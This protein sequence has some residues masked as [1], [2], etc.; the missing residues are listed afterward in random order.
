MRPAN[1]HGGPGSRFERRDR[2][3]HC[4][5]EPLPCRNRASLHSFGSIGM[6]E[7]APNPT[8]TCNRVVERRIACTLPVIRGRDEF[9]RDEL[10]RARG[11]RRVKLQQLAHDF[12]PGFQGAFIPARVPLSVAGFDGSVGMRRPRCD[13]CAAEELRR[14]TMRSCRARFRGHADTNGS[15]G[16][17][18]GLDTPASSRPV[19]FATL[20]GS[21]VAPR[22]FAAVR[23]L[24]RRASTLC[25][26]PC[27]RWKET[28][29]RGPL[30][31]RRTQGA[32]QGIGQDACGRLSNTRRSHGLDD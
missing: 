21:V 3:F 7:R 27:A 12:L 14:V 25:R 13:G 16:G 22:R 4:A 29:Y 15:L 19:E 31:G 9:R 11:R 28:M 2:N 10:Q 32:P 1:N 18:V 26:C 6:G 20:S 8:G 17:H 30:D 5:W 24:Q 23:V